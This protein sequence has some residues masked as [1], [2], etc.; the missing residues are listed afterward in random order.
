MAAGPS[1]VT[2]FRYR[3]FISYSHGDKSWAGWLHRA[4]ESYVVPI[5]LV[6][7]Q[8]AAGLI[9]PRL[10]PIFRDREELASASNLGDK[11]EAA[12]RQSANLIVICSPRAS[13][14]RWVNEEVAAYQLLGR[15][16]RIFCLIV[17]GEPHA[18]DDTECLP[19]ALGLPA[20]RANETSPQPIEPVAADA[21][22][23]QDGKRGALLKLVAGLLDVG[24][25][26]LR[27]REHQRRV[28]RL[29]VITALALI[30]ATVATALAVSALL[31]RQ[32]AE[33]ARIAAERRQQQAENL[34]DFMIGDLNDKLYQ[35]NRLDILESVADKAM[36]Y[37]ADLPVADVTDATLAQRASALQMIGGIRMDQG[38]L[39][40]ARMALQLA[41]AIQQER[42]RHAPKSAEVL[43]E[44]GYGHTWVGV[45]YWQQ[46]DNDA[47]QAEFRQAII[48]LDTSLAINPDKAETRH[49]LA[50]AHNNLGQT[51]L[52]QG[53]K[54]AASDAFEA[55]LAAYRRL[56]ADAADNT[57]YATGLGTS[58][59]A[60]SQLALAKGD[61][62]QAIAYDV[63]R[64]RVFATLAERVPNDRSVTLLLAIS[65]ATLASDLHL[66]G[67]TQ[68]AMAHYDRAVELTAELKEYDPT[69]TRNMSR[70]AIYSVQ[71]VSLR[72]EL[73]GASSP[74]SNLAEASR[75]LAQMA[76]QSPDNDEFHYRSA[77]AQLETA[78]QM[79]QAGDRIGAQDAAA[80]ALAT[81]A[82]YLDKP[83]TDAGALGTA[84]RV[85][86]L[87]AEVTSSPEQHAARALAHTRALVPESEDPRDLA[88]RVLAQLANHQLAAAK[89]GIEKLR[90]GGYRPIGF[91]RAMQRHGIDYPPEPTF[92]QQLQ[93][94]MAEPI[95]AASKQSP[96]GVETD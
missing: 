87:L 64:H 20:N 44:L 41:L 9:P 61:L 92:K 88:I 93:L 35:V 57:R 42:L 2:D 90:L 37:F 11:V 67:S 77:L 14:S 73:S 19:S 33:Q 84:S 65:N 4:L 53:D 7:R 83:S 28:R 25:D 23:G 18:G 70:W 79:A 95:P 36:E 85:E 68:A 47:A 52:A 10:S 34:V 17:D 54:A 1:T 3:A 62:L 94:A 69:N 63:A 21:R 74:D 86:L 72:R 96:V 22:P 5:R 31:A 13:T 80:R 55:E 76:A 27:Q 59:G 26:E 8:T 78:Q 81:L 29:T 89:P 46:G 45:V 60:L 71:Q 58:Y 49:R 56:L 48:A 82:P 16:E 6:G 32:Q 30:A 12:L 91:V 75:L 40:K 39:D 51:L 15:A 24:L 50:M 38:H 66:A 43:A